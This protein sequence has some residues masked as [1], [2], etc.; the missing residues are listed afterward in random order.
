MLVRLIM[1]GGRLPVEVRPLTQRDLEIGG[2]NPPPAIMQKGISKKQ[3]RLPARDQG[4]PGGKNDCLAVPKGGI[5]N[6][7]PDKEARSGDT[8]KVG[9]I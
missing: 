9:Y 6:I 7:E 2:S 4:G 8:D 5:P 1:G 3:R